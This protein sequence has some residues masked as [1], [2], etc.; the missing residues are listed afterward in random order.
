MAPTDTAV[1]NAKPTP[2]P[3]SP[4]TGAGCTFSSPPP[5]GKLWRPQYR[6]EG[7]Q[8]MLAMGAYPEVGLADARERRTEARKLP[9][10]GD[11]SRR[12]PEGGK[13]CHDRPNGQHLRGRRE[14]GTR[15]RSPL[16]RSPTRGSR[17]NGSSMT[18]SPP[19]AQ[20]RSPTSPPP[21]V[22]VKHARNGHPQDAF[23]RSV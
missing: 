20:D 16:G 23:C 18:S 7:K 8:K 13:G 3:A 1:R 9:A 11:R 21:R 12:G 19:W 10:Q 17:S 15:S 4:P 6:F 14:R 22:R 2:S 5:G